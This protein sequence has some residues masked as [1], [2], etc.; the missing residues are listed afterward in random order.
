M[1]E[2]EEWTSLN[3]Y[4]QVFSHEERTCPENSVNFFP[5]DVIYPGA[6]RILLVLR[7]EPG[8]LS[9][10]LVLRLS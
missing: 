7:K 4:R 6:Y 1:V 10:M 9:K 5:L 3:K 2:Y 8:Y